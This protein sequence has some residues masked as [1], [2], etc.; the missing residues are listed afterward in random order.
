MLAE[1]SP[2]QIIAQT[3]DSEFACDHECTHFTKFIKSNG[4]VCVRIQ[5]KR[6]GANV[7]EV[8][9]R[10]HDTNKLPMFDEQLRLSWWEK[11]QERHTE[12]QQEQQREITRQAQ[13]KNAEWWR[14]YN[15]YLRSQAWYDIRK[16]VLERD[17][18]ICQACLRN[19][20]SQVHHLSYEL[21]EQLGRSAAFELVAI[22]YQCHKAIHP[23]LAEAQHEV[24]E[25]LH[26]PYLVGGTNG[27][28]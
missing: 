3:L 23:H 17:N 10:D 5:C 28:R 22:C 1:L 7:K 20:A 27:H 15:Q 24:V 2:W 19:K 14:K 8:A 13:E 26:N 4:V 11:R 6:C 25:K 18:N 12:L 16:R 21:Y 9:K